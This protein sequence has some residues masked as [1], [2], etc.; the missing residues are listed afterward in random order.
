AALEPREIWICWA[1]YVVAV[2]Y[3]LATSHWY[4]A[5]QGV[6]RVRELQVSNLWCGLGFVTVAALLLLLDWGL[7]A[8]VVATAV[9]GGLSCLVCRRAFRQA[10]PDGPSGRVAPD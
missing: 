5:C 4:V 2:G 7:F 8:M 10:V 6:N 9:R 3:S 1:L